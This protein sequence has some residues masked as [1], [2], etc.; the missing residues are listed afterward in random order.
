M[1]LISIARHAAWQTD[2][3]VFHLIN[4]QAGNWALDWV[5]IFASRTYLFNGAIIMAAYWYIWFLPGSHQDRREKIVLALIGAIITLIVARGFASILPYRV[6]PLYA[7]DVGYLSPHL[8]SGQTI[9]GYEDWSSFPSDQ[10]A[11]FF[12]LAAGLWRCSR[13]LGVLA[14]LVAIIGVCA[15]QIYLGIHYPSDVIAGAALGV[16]CVYA[17]ARIGSNRLT[18]T[19]LAFER[20]FSPAFYAAMFLVTFEI[21]SLFDDVRQLMHGVLVALRASGMHSLNLMVVLAVGVGTLTAFALAVG[22]IVKARI[23]KRGGF[24]PSDPA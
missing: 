19:I 5:A 9:A 8:P 21:G 24:F 23:G 13:P 3:W 15:V 11:L 6:R 17:T 18:R 4:G 1:G 2:L 20:D 22:F 7:L 12:A 16:L 10:A 14:I